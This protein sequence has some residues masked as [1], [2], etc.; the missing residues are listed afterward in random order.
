[1]M[2]NEPST[3]CNEKKKNSFFDLSYDTNNECL[4]NLTKTIEKSILSNLYKLFDEK[5]VKDINSNSNVTNSIGNAGL[6][7]T[8]M[9][10]D[11]FEL[12]QG[13]NEYDTNTNNND[14]MEETATADGAIVS[15]ETKKKSREE[16]IGIRGRA[17]NLH[18]KEQKKRR[19]SE[20]RNKRLKII[21]DNLTRDNLNQE[22]ESGFAAMQ[23]QSRAVPCVPTAQT[24]TMNKALAGGL[25]T[26]QQDADEKNMQGS[27]MAGPAFRVA[28]QSHPSN[29]IYTTNMQTPP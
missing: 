2:Q 14:E 13:K 7:E 9:T 15:E 24:E 23:N 11:L 29:Y 28:P 18:L 21:R 10:N 4:K 22:Q 5:N 20:K 3:S 25:T 6:E 1:M 19:R 12:S 8:A 17:W 26:S 27:S 16:R